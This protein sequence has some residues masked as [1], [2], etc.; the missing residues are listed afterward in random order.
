MRPNRLDKEHCSP[1]VF[2]YEQPYQVPYKDAD[3]QR[4]VPVPTDKEIL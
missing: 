3:V 4:E 1:E 2:S